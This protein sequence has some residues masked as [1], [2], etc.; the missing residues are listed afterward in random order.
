MHDQPGRAEQRAGLLDVIEAGRR[1]EMLV[2]QERHRRSAGDD[3][4]E[5]AAVEHALRVLVAVDQLAQR[6]VHRRFV[7]ARPLHVAA[8][9]EQL[10]AAVLLRTERGEPLRAVQDDERHVAERL[11][12]VHRGRALIEAGDG[13]ER[14]LD[15]RLRALAFERFDE[16]RLLARLVGAGAAVHVDVA[17]EAAA[18]DVLAEEP[19]LVGLLDRRARASPARGRTRRGCRCRRPSRRWRS[20]RS[21]TP[22]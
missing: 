7:D 17:V 8:D 9:A 5:R 1:V 13:R 10:R 4:L 21:R 20:S 11:D 2:E 16:R 6:R 3:R 22:R 12:V 15:A 18:E 14:R 19:G